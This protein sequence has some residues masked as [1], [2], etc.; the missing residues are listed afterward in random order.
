MDFKLTENY[1]VVITMRS[2]DVYEFLAQGDFVNFFLTHVREQSPQFLEVYYALGQEDQHK[3]AAYLHTA[4]I[5]QIQI[6]PV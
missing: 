3:N 4:H 5:E 1:N 2:G 6:A